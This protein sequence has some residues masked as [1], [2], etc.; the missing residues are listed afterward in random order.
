MFIKLN[1]NLIIPLALN[2][3]S[4]YQKILLFYHPYDKQ[5]QHFPQ[6]PLY[7]DLKLYFPLA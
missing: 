4:A 2:S 3:F 6:G 7:K 5:N 1:D